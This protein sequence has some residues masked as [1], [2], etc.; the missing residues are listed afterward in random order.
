MNIEL[1]DINESNQAQVL[2]LRVS[3]NQVD[4]IE[5]VAQC[6]KEAKDCE[7][8]KPIGLKIDGELV[9]FAMYGH[10][11]S[12]DAYGRVWL[13]R[14]LIDERFQ[15]LGYGSLML[16]YLLCFLIDKYGKRDIYLSLFE[17]NKQALQMY[18]KLGFVFNGELDLNG[19]KI[20]CLNI[21]LDD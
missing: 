4:Y 1:V 13:D 20:M 7:Y 9:G 21:T 3:E 5:T 12:P 6:L 2:K 14:F 11:P 8:Y 15:G 19:E 10:F 17:N 18:Q 16:E